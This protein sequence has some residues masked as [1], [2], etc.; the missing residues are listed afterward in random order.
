MKLLVI[1][2]QYKTIITNIEKYYRQNKY[3]YTLVILK[4]CHYLKPND[5]IAVFKKMH[6]GVNYGYTEKK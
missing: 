4:S 6:V 3:V 2:S 1:Q 5:I